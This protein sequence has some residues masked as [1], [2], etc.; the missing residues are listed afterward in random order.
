MVVPRISLLKKLGADIPAPGRVDREA[1]LLAIAVGDKGRL[2]QALAQVAAGGERAAE[3]MLAEPVSKLMGHADPEICAA[4]VKAVGAMGAAALRFAD[5]IAEYLLKHPDASCRAAALAALAG[6]GSDSDRLVRQ[7]VASCVSDAEPSVRASALQALAAMQATGQA[8]QVRAAMA[9]DP[10]EAVRSAALETL[11]SFVAASE[12]VEGICSPETLEA[13]LARM[14]ADAGSRL[15][16]LAAIRRLGDKAPRACVGA[17]VDALS[18][19]DGETRQAAAAA[20]GALGGLVVASP[21]AVRGLE[22]AL[23]SPEPGARAAAAHAAGLLG[24]HGAGFAGAVAA[25]LAD[26]LEDPSSFPAQ[27]GGA[28]ARLPPQLRVPRCAAITALG[29]LGDA[30]RIDKVVTALG[31]H[32]SWE[33][34]LAACEALG[35]FGQAARGEADSLLNM[36]EDDAY[37]VRAAA[38]ASLGALGNAQALPMLIQ[39]LDDRASSVRVGALG[40]LRRL[41][42]DA[43]EYSHDVFR[44]LD[45]P[46]P[47]VRCAAIDCLASFGETGRMYAGV[48]GTMMCEEQPEVRCAA[49]R[50]LG[51]LGPQGAAFAPEIAERASQD[52]SLA[53]RQ[54]ANDALDALSAEGLL[55]A[56]QGALQDNYGYAGAAEALAEARPRFEGLGLYYA[57]IQEQK[58][59][60]QSSGQWIEGIF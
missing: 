59:E 43:A 58:K 8:R 56:G 46:V 32:S 18:D 15:A 29:R 38:C 44:L 7:A 54:A 22:A 3:L 19:R 12:E 31:D 55:S 35:D 37:P 33:V 47:K 42:A 40:A 5:D 24:Q 2:L 45:D 50:A 30:S 57:E 28:A 11:A 27:I 21:E 20:V 10:S 13:P 49:L 4:A 34:R 9:E 25:L 6:Q 39:R 36:L 48:I 17:V 53:A 60:L 1:V 51:R 52:R 23:S 16:A 14:L 41:G 26:D